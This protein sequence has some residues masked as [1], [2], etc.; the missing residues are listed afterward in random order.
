MDIQGNQPDRPFL[1]KVKQ[2][3]AI[4]GIP[5]ST[6]YEILAKQELPVVRLGRAVRI[7]REELEQWIDGHKSQ[8]G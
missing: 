4:Y 5:R 7:P 8:K 1:L 2:V 3:E 6:L